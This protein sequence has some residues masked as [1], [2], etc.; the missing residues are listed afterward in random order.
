M[1]AGRRISWSRLHTL[2]F[3]ILA[4]EAHWLTAQPAVV[5]RG[6][7]RGSAV[8]AP[9]AQSLQNQAR[10]L[11][12]P[13][14]AAARCCAVRTS[15]SVA[16]AAQPQRHPKQLTSLLTHTADADAVLGVHA[17][18]GKSFNEINLATC[19]S[20]LARVSSASQR[21]QWQDD[22]SVL[23]ALRSQTAS[24]LSRL[25]ARSI[26]STAHSLA[27]LGLHGAEWDGLWSELCTVAAGQ[28]SK[29]EAQG[30]TMTAWA[31]ARR[32]Q[33]APVLFDSIAAEA[34]PRL[35]DFKPQE[36]ANTAWAFAA[37]GHAAPALFDALSASARTQLLS[38]KPLEL[39]SLA[40]SFATTGH[41]ASALFDAISVACPAQLSTYSAQS[42]ANLAWAFAKQ[43]H[44]SP[45]FFQALAR[46]SM[47]RLA[48]FKP[49]ELANLAWACARAEY[50]DDLFYDQL[51]Y[52][53][54][55]RLAEFKAQ[56]LAGVAWAFSK[57][58]VRLGGEG[59][60]G[61]GNWSKPSLVGGV[62]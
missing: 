8:I 32:G 58:Q 49:M 29:F 46:A 21:R 38:F 7:L 52:V 30:L 60:G 4:V 51:E 23:A 57:R 9:S 2:L 48:E 40:W 37:S 44:R 36:L 10:L 62:G 6:A 27:R 5:Q 41:A 28:V 47:S 59:G 17:Q 50:E 39:S 3:C 20:A 12:A 1:P 19:W 14:A 42:L 31:F 43:G 15:S 55:V 25:D 18:Y 11:T 61:R 53:C 24:R 33:P 26:A 13:R 45:P 34:A 22:A 35:S 16:L 54:R 56:E